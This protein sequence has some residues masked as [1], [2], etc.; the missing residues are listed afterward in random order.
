[1]GGNKN[2]LIGIAT[3]HGQCRLSMQQ[4]HHESTYDLCT[5]IYSILFTICIYKYTMRVCIKFESLF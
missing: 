4:K 5:I 1:M 2:S 3:L